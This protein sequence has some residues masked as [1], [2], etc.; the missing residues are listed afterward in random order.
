MACIVVNGVGTGI[1][2]NGEGGTTDRGRWAGWV[3]GLH[4]PATVLGTLLELAFLVKKQRDR[5]TLIGLSDHSA[6]CVRSRNEESQSLR[7]ASTRSYKV[8]LF[9]NYH[10]PSSK[11]EVKFVW[12]LGGTMRCDAL[13]SGSPTLTYVENYTMTR[14]TLVLRSRYD[15]TG[16]LFVRGTSRNRVF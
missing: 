3:G 5:D 14:D 2:G 15:V 4:S 6:L 8:L 11:L 12:Q 16:C 10:N 9:H 7:L 13:A 1:R